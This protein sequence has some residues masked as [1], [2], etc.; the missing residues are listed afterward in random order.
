MSEEID[1]SEDEFTISAINNLAGALLSLQEV[2]TDLLSTKR[3]AKLA[4]MKRQIFDTLSFY[5]DCLPEII[6]DEKEG[7]K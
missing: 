3:K 2:E 5:C 1:Y 7:E 4:R 6:E